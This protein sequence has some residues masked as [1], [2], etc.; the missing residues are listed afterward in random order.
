M[1]I[2]DRVKEAIEAYSDQGYHYE[3]DFF[4]LAYPSEMDVKGFEVELVEE[5]G[6]YEGGGED[7]WRVLKFVAPDGESCL[8]KFEGTYYSYVGSEYVRYYF[9]DAVPV[10]RIDYVERVQ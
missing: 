9:V 6:G 1:T 5:F 8:V 3:S 4:D 2:Y 7:Q 10:Q